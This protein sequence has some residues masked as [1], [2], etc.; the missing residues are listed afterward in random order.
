[1]QHSG[2]CLMIL[3]I[4]KR[5]PSFMALVA[6]LLAT[7]LL[8]GCTMAEDNDDDSALESWEVEEPSAT[9]DTTPEEAFITRSADDAVRSSTDDVVIEAGCSIVEYCDASGSDGARCLQQGCSLQ[10][11]QNECWTETHKVCGNPPKC[12]WIFVAT[13]GNRYFWNRPHCR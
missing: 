10:A 12:L 7:F 11:A 2:R 5:T 13:N 1:M 8:V 4:G 9:G 3:R 6:G